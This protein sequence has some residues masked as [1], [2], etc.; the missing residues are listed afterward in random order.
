MGGSGRRTAAVDCGE[1]TGHGYSTC[2][3]ET[4]AVDA[5]VRAHRDKCKKLRKRGGTY[6]VLIHPT[7]I[8]CAVSVKCC[9]GKEENVSH[10]DHW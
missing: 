6:T 7:S 10:Y 9:C 3:T 8:A 4:K 5:W 1:N 2:P